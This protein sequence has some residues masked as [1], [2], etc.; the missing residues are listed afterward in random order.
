MPH[1]NNGINPFKLAKYINLYVKDVKEYLDKN[2]IP[3]KDK[4][5]IQR[6]AE[7]S[8]QDPEM[9]KI[10]TEAYEMVGS[11]GVVNVQQTRE[12]GMN[13]ELKK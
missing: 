9:A 8:S 1:I 3:V 2:A 10:I 11:D 12:L 6:V 7:I 13:I 4:A 5:Q